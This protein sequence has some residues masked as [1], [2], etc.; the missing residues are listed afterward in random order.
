MLV[1]LV[2]APAAR[3]ARV[4][5]FPSSIQAQISG[6]CSL[7]GG[8]ASAGSDLAG[9]P[10]SAEADRADLHHDRAVVVF[11]S[12]GGAANDLRTRSCYS[13]ILSGRATASVL[14][15]PART[16][17]GRGGALGLASFCWPAAREAAAARPVGRAR[18]GPHSVGL[19]ATR[20]PF[21]LTHRPRAVGWPAQPA[22]V[23]GPYAGGRVPGRRSLVVYGRG[24][25]FAR[26]CAAFDLQAGF[27][28]GA[29]AVAGGVVRTSFDLALG[30]VGEHRW[31]CG[32]WLEAFGCHR[33]EAD[34]RPSRRGHGGGEEHDS[35]A[36]I[37]SVARRGRCLD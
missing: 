17:H 15:R 8:C 24:R 34:A 1:G 6:R 21:W 13:S 25:S 33:S 16:D 37:C 10:E 23:L 35:A 31:P 20:G 11:A 4:L 30:P 14:L 2:S 3:W 9:P 18:P 29:G 36:P 27:G 28:V 26:S 32:W 19:C 7:V 5:V 12:L 22:Y